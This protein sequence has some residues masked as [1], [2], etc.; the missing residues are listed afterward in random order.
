MYTKSMF[1]VVFLHMA[2][3][4]RKQIR[5]HVVAYCTG[6]R[7]LRQTCAPR[8]TWTQGDGKQMHKSYFIYRFSKTGSNLLCLWIIFHRR[9]NT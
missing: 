7:N 3:A 6:S 5:S 1:L 9:A 8:K 2:I 4:T